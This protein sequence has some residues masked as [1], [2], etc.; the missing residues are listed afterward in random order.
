[1]QTTS[2]KRLEVSV[3]K[4]E[5]FEMELIPM[6]INAKTKNKL[7]TIEENVG[8][9]GK[10]ENNKQSIILCYGS[11][12]KIKIYINPILSKKMELALINS[13]NTKSKIS[14]SHLNVKSLEIR[15]F[16]GLEADHVEAETLTFDKKLKELNLNHSVK[17]KSFGTK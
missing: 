17:F 1:M 8:Y 14:I 9:I 15:G 4:A 10:T 5:N 13:E 3:P 2:I 7:F 11:D 16:Y 6:P 12:S